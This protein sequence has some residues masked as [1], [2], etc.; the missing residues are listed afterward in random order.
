MV[1]Y[2]LFPEIDPYSTATLIIKILKHKNINDLLLM[3]DS[4]GANLAC[5][6]LQ[7]LHDSN[8]NYVKKAIL[9]SPFIDKSLNNKK[10]CL[11]GVIG[12]GIKVGVQT[13]GNYLV[14]VLFNSL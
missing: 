10:I 8:L 9:I 5:F 3:G 11:I 13:G 4:A 6:V 1:Q 12:L 14:S 7:C 2:P